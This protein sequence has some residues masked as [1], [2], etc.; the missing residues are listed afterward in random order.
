MQNNS[1]LEVGPS[2]NTEVCPSANKRPRSE[3]ALSDIDISALFELSANND[4]P[5][6][7]D[8]ETEIPDFVENKTPL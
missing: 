3:N 5:D 1:V 4:K 6:H 2:T 8:M 7:I